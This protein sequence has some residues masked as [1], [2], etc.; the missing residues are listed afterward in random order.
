MSIDAMEKTLRQWA[1][2]AADQDISEPQRQQ[3]KD[4]SV[5][6]S[7]ALTYAGRDRLAAL[8]DEIWNPRS[9]R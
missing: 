6:A 3:I 2:L 1:R 4:W 7:I 5:G 8:A 9:K